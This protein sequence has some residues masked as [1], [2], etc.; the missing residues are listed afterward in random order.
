MFFSKQSQAKVVATTVAG[1]LASQLTSL[2]PV[3]LQRLLRLSSDK[4]C[5]VEL[6]SFTLFG[7][8]DFWENGWCSYQKNCFFT[9]SEKRSTLQSMSWL[10]CSII[11]SLL[12]S[13]ITCSHGACSIHRSPV[14]IGVLDQMTYVEG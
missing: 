8:F 5:E 3:N 4:V 14:V 7:F 6:G 13:T 2:L 9:V 12:W 10:W 1:F 11:F